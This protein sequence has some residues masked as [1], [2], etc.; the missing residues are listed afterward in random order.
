MHNW[1]LSEVNCQ[2]NKQK[3]VFMLDCYRESKKLAGLHTVRG[4]MGPMLVKP[5]V[6][7][8]K[9][10]WWSLGKDVDWIKTLRA[11]R[12]QING[13]ELSCPEEKGPLTW[14]KPKL[15]LTPEQLHEIKQ[16]T[17]NW[18][19]FRSGE[20]RHFV[21]LHLLRVRWHKKKL[22]K[23]LWI[24]KTTFNIFSVVSVWTASLYSGENTVFH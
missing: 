8:T 22:E 16:L 17:S 20:A 19:N 13:Q 5:L 14:I 24:L 23:P 11:N 10:L 18:V 4:W 15:L 1:L 21:R 7:I 6:Y 3:I 2:C 12:C 9:A